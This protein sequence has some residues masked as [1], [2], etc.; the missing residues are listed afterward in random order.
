MASKM[1]VYGT[2]SEEEIIKSKLDEGLVLYRMGRLAEAKRSFQEILVIRPH[3]T[4]ANYWKK[5]VMRDI[6]AEHDKRGD[7]AF[8]EENYEKAMNQWYDALM[9]RENDPKLIDKIA[10]AENILR[11]EK[12]NR[13]LTKAVEYYN[14]GNLTASSKQ[15][16]EAL[17]IQ[18]G[19]AQIERLYE[20]VNVEIGEN[21]FN[22]GS[23]Y[24]QQGKYDSAIKNFKES[25][26][27]GYSQKKISDMIQQAQNKKEQARLEA[28]RR[29]REA[30]QKAFEED[31]KQVKEQEEEKGLEEELYEDEL[32]EIVVPIVVN[33]DVV[34]EE[35]RLAS[36][37]L[38]KEGLKYFNDGDFE[39]ART[40]FL[41][42]IK[43]DPGNLDAEAGLDRIK[44]IFGED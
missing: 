5:I 25:L 31:L 23:K 30:M 21:Y 13:V 10:R 15:F 4:K 16:E 29:K 35:A 22:I 24:Y 19:D 11:K 40:K 37:N 39:M 12:L 28:E 20:Q 8:E 1:G 17:K 41:E 18:P 9:I 14:Q 3:N 34:S 38:Y 33:Q 7:K 2:T 32:E 42:A 26:K 44:A 43:V 6:A 36:Q 27:W